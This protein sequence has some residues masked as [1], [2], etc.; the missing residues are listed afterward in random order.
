MAERT[1]RAEEA[2]I[3]G[4]ARARTRTRTM[5]KDGKSEKKRTEGDTY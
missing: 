5:V 4:G 3:T 2:E 1:E